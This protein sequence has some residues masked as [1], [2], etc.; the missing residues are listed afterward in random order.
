MIPSLPANPADLA[1]V[2][3]GGGAKGSYQVGVFEALERLSIR[4]GA[5]FGASV[6]ALNAAMLARGAWEECASLW[7]SLRL[8]DLVT[9]ESVALLEKAEA[10]PSRREKL[11]QLLAD[12]VQQRFVDVGPLRALLARCAGEDEL[13]KGSVRFGLVATRVSGL[14][15]VEKTLEEMVP[16]SLPDWLM[17]SAACFPIFPIQQI[18]G[19]GY[20]DG[21]YCDNVPVGMAVA[22]GARHVIAV[23]NGRSLAHERTLRR[24]NVTYI[25]A[26]RPLGG[27]MRFSPERAAFNRRLGF[28]D[29]MRALGAYRGV[30]WSFE[31]HAAQAALPLAEDFVLALGRMETALLPDRALSLRG[32]DYA[33]FFPLL[34]P[35]LGARRDALDHLLAAC[36]LVCE[37]AELDPL[38]VYTLASLREAL[39]RALPLARARALIASMD[40]MRLSARL[41]QLFAPALPDR[42]LTV[43]CLAE[44]LG[45]RGMDFPLSVYAASSFPAEFLC[46][47]SL[48]FLLGAPEDL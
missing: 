31:G 43:C 48:S 37:M 4:A 19:E 27:L 14:R 25:R 1:L 22:R 30:R 34:E 46:A 40:G 39:W 36:E 3:G 20:I 29:T 28:N 35:H 15:M 9:P 6:G 33:P 2:L 47:L 32:K 44:L 13:R 38:A 24:P 42:K 18:D 5:V 11:A 45:R 10:L 21:G 23:D 26:S 7:E 8:T 17:A 12:S 41:A 16:G